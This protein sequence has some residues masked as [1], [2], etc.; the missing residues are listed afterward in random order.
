MQ[1]HPLLI[2]YTVFVGV[3]C[4][5]TGISLVVLAFKKKARRGRSLFRNILGEIVFRL[6]FALGMLLILLVAAGVGWAV[7]YW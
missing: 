1:P 6:H 3:I 4:L 5:M 2:G 7:V